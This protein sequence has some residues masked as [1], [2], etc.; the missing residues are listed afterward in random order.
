MLPVVKVLNCLLTGTYF[1]DKILI[2][3]NYLFWVEA[4]PLGIGP[5]KPLDEDRGREFFTIPLFDGLKHFQADS[6]IGRYLLQAYSS[7]L[8]FS[9]QKF[10]EPFHVLTT[11][12]GDHDAQT[13]LT[14]EGTKR[15]ADWRLQISG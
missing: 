9:S 3:N 4:N 12:Y 7:C 13:A 15:I 6:G 2:A 1:L 10:T 11:R 8:P 14:T 5:E